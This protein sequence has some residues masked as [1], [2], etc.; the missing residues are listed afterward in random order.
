MLNVLP[1]H[2]LPDFLSSLVNSSF[3]EKLEVLDA[4]ELSDRF[5]LALSLLQRQVS[6]R[7]GVWSGV[8]SKTLLV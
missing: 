7:K 2:K 8:W 4:V 5:R 3:E 6:V 1:D